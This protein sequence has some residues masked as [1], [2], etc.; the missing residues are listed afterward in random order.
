[1][2]KIE[3]PGFRTIN[4]EHCAV[5]PG[6]IDT[7]GHAGHSMV[8]TVAEGHEDWGLLIEDIYLRGVKNEFWY[9]DGLLASLER[10]KFG[11]TTGVSFL[12]GGGII[13]LAASLARP[14]R[15]QAEPRQL[16]SKS[17]AP[18][19]QRFLLLS[20]RSQRRGCAPPIQCTK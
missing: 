6:L 8:K 1:M 4:A 13:C 17:R 10:L 5:L 20:R 14:T 7:H 2:I 12:G 9:T 19:S 3:I 15:C 11:T 18:L 16:Q